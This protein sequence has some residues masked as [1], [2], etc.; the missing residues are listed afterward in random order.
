MLPIPK[1]VAEVSGRLLR[2]TLFGCVRGIRLNLGAFRLQIE[3]YLFPFVRWTQLK[4]L[5]C[6]FEY[7]VFKHLV[8]KFQNRT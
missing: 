3:S 7:N 4:F 6:V 1:N 8:D 5:L 2:A